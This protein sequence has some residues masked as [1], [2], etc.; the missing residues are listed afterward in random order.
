M[1]HAIQGNRSIVRHIRAGPRSAGE[2]RLSRL[3]GAGIVPV[4]HPRYDGNAIGVTQ[5][6]Q[7][8]CATGAAH[9]GCELGRWIRDHVPPE[10]QARIPRV[11]D[12]L[13]GRSHWLLADPTEDG[14]IPPGRSTQEDFD[15]FWRKVE[16]NRML[17]PAD[18]G[19]P[20]EQT[21]WSIETSLRER[22][23]A[24]LGLDPQVAAVLTI[25]ELRTIEASQGGVA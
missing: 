2:S 11:E 1:T 5:N 6:G 3:R 16:S 18:D 4:F 20:P 8:F 9:C 12:I 10:V 23:V 21:V 17:K 15:A 24:K 19:A 22:L 7:R 14:S 25:E 13:D